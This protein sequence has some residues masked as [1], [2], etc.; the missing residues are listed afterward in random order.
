M[1]FH[2]IKANLFSFFLGNAKNQLP[3]EDV[4]RTFVNYEAEN[5]F[6]L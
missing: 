3:S 2:P 1:L 6:S 5:K 4:E